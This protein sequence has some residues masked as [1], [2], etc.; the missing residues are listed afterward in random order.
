MSDQDLRAVR[1][2]Y[3]DVIDEIVV[4]VRRGEKLTEDERNWVANILE[5][6]RS[7][8]HDNWFWLSHSVLKKM[9]PEK[10]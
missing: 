8:S 10:T 6:Q 3:A 1:D 4:K 5:R 9:N 7:Q 2:A